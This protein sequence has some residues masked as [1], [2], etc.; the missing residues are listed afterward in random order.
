MKKAICI[1]DKEKCCGCTACFSVCPVDAICMKADEEGFF[2][3]DINLQKCIQC[4][5]CVSVCPMQEKMDSGEPCV[6]LAVKN[7]DNSV[8][9]ASSSGGVFTRLAEIIEKRSGTIY[10]AAFDKEFNVSHKRAET[11]K[12][13]ETFRCSKYVQSDLNNVFQ[14]V[15]N[16]LSSGRYVLFTGTPC[17]VQG[18]QNVLKGKN[19]EKL[20]ICDIVCHGTPS[21]QIW[22]DYLKYIQKK[23]G[24]KIQKINF[25][26]KSKGGWHNSTITMWDCEGKVLLQE[27][28][29]ENFYFQMFLNHFIL[30]PSCHECKFAN[31]HRV[32][33]ITLGDFW[34]IEKNYNKYDDNMGISLVLLNTKKGMYMWSLIEEEF[35]VI[36]VKK[37]QCLQPNLCAPSEKN[38]YRENFWKAYQKHGLDYAGK[39]VRIIQPNFFERVIMKLDKM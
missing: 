18:L 17:Q 34:G 25:R 12:E 1:R 32:G 19:T 3:P 23:R 10:G 7:R 33:D 14:K 30:R 27:N 38:V 15:Q 6:Y 4:G 35:E 29:K 24:R 36:T 20:I 11:K 28:Q 22:K 9:K 8:R 13:W 16:D 31:L 39:K 26:D 2:Y 5:K 21:P 37:D